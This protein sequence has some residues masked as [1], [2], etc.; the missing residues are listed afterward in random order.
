M[1][2]FSCS[3]GVLII[4]IVSCFVKLS[5]AARCLSVRWLI[6]S[7]YF[8]NSRWRTV[9]ACWLKRLKVGTEMSDP[10]QRSHSSDFCSSIA[11]ALWISVFLASRFFSTMARSASMLYEMTLAMPSTPA[12]TLRGTDTSTRTSG[13][14]RPARPGWLAIPSRVTTGSVA[15]VAKN[16]TSCAETTSYTSERGYKVMSRSAPNSFCKAA[17]PE[18]SSTLL[19]HRAMLRGARDFSSS[20]LRCTRISRAILPEPTMATLVSLS[21]LRRSAGTTSSAN[22]TAAEEIE[23]EPFAMPVCERTALPNTT[24]CSRRPEITLPPWPPSPTAARWHAV[25]WDRI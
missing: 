25:T 16:A 4:L 24:A 12:S 9:S 1:S 15:A 22:S 8:S 6:A 11:S 10:C 14:V 23:T 13:D 17:A 5:T 2:F 3:M 19:L 20:D 21:G 18:P 7:L